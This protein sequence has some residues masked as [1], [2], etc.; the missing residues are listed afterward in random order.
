MK[1]T[2]IT[3]NGTVVNIED[4]PKEIAKVIDNLGQIRTAEPRRGVLIPDPF[5]LLPEEYLN[6][7]VKLTEFYD[8]LRQHNLFVS[9]R[10]WSV[11]KQSNIALVKMP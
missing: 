1:A 3:S 4:T 9:R 2:I 5:P 7:F 10:I 6:H 8:L 11:L